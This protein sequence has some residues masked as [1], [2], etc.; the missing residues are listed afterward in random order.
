[1]GRESISWEDFGIAARIERERSN[2]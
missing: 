2:H 1:M